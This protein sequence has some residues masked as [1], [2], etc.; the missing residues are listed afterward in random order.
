VFKANHSPPCSAKAKNERRN[1]FIPPYGFIAYAGT[2]LPLP[3]L[4]LKS[5]KEFHLEKDI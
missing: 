2:F 5:S 4:G 1:T 3:L